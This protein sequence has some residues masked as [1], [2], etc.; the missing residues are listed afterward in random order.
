MAG[1]KIFEAA[2]A[3][4]SAQQ[5]VASTW[6]DKELKIFVC[7]DEGIHDLHGAARIDVAIQ[8]ADEQEQLSL[9]AMSL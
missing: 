8:L 1:E 6:N 5:A 4:R 9:E 7:T 2:P 3:V